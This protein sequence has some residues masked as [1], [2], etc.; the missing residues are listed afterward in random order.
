MI[1]VEQAL[2]SKKLQNLPPNNI[3]FTQFSVL[4][5]ESILENLQV[6]QPHDNLVSD[7]GVASLTKIR[8]TTSRV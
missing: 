6:D 3:H 4:C 1:P 5:D 7:T 2:N 8:K